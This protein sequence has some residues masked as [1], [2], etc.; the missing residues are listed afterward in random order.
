[1]TAKI[2]LRR[3]GSMRPETMTALSP[4]IYEYPTVQIRSGSRMVQRTPAAP[5]SRSRDSPDVE[6]TSSKAQRFQIWVM[7]LV[8]AATSPTSSNDA[9]HL[10]LL[11]KRRL[12]SLLGVV[13]PGSRPDTAK[14]KTNERAP[15]GDYER[16]RK[17][18]PGRRNLPG[19]RLRQMEGKPSSSTPISSRLRRMTARSITA[20]SSLTLPGQR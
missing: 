9:G 20:E 8:L 7:R 4:Q 13:G 14:I 12:W 3:N 10:S 5:A 19:I 1:M 11:W 2:W 16:R 15:S 17:C 6:R 18:L